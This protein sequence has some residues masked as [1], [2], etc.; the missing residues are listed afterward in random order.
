MRDY[1]LDIDHVVGLV[2]GNEEIIRRMKEV[3]KGEDRFGI[4]HT[5]LSELYYLIRSSAQMESNIAALTELVSDLYVWGY[6][7]GAAEITGEILTQAKSLS[8]PLSYIEAQIAAVARQRQAV[9]LSG[10]GRFA[11]VRDIE[12]QNWLTPGAARH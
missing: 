12:L 10:S 5:T 6:D 2:S 9:L 8:R 1:I 4:T 11:D 7:R 3:K